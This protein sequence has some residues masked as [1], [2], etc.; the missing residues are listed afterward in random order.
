MKLAHLINHKD[1]GDISVW[2]VSWLS[3]YY[4]LISKNTE[5]FKNVFLPKY[6]CLDIDLNQEQLL[7]GWRQHKLTKWQSK[8][9]VV[10]SYPQYWSVKTRF[11]TS[12]RIAVWSPLTLL[13]PHAVSKTNLRSWEQLKLLSATRNCVDQLPHWSECVNLQVRSRDWRR[14]HLAI[15]S[16]LG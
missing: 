1:G 15:E 8:G 9:L 11:A 5:F 6:T 10:T 2:Y 3:T 4:G 14:S 13:S 16:F 12:H 7:A